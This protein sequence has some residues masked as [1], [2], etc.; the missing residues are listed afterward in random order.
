[1]DLKTTSGTI[2]T[3]GVCLQLLRSE[4]RR[5]GWWT[6]RQGGM[7]T[8]MEMALWSSRQTSQAGRIQVL[9][10]V[11]VVSALRITPPGSWKKAV[12]FLPSHIQFSQGFWHV[13]VFLGNPDWRQGVGKV[14][15]RGCSASPC[16]EGPGWLTTVTNAQLS[17]SFSA[18]GP[19]GHPSREGIWLLFIPGRWEPRLPLAPGPGLGQVRMRPRA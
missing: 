11:A 10:L 18:C 4:V 3:V 17:S 8:G 9:S 7:G 1:M 19:Q 12:V 6:L 5:R 15:K 16:G 2:P 14:F 13:L